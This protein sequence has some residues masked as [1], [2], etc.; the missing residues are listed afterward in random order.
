VAYRELIVAAWDRD[1]LL[2]KLVR[3][4]I[5]KNGSFAISA[6]YHPERMG[7]LMKLPIREGRGGLR[8][9]EPRDREV[10]YRVSGAVKLIY[11]STGF[12]QFSQG[13]RQ[14]IRSGR[15]PGSEFLIPKGLGME[16]YP[17]TNPDTRGP[18]LHATF[19]GIEACEPVTQGGRTTIL[20][21]L[22]RPSGDLGQQWLP[23]DGVIIAFT[24]FSPSDHRDAYWNGHQ[25]ILDWQLWGEDARFVLLDLP[26]PLAFLGI[27]AR[28]SR[29]TPA[30]RTT[31]G[32]E[33]YLQGPPSLLEQYVLVAHYP[34]DERA[35]DLPT[36]DFPADTK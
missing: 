20:P 36:I 35:T 4:L 19:Y 30:G 27:G 5:L 18:T 24:I 31:D 8:I 10:E 28:G 1:N 9:I 16:A 11:H 33:Y 25:W 14:R 12:V 3:V 32:P 34:A 22:G 6:P 17:I 7:T 13:D 26:T 23:G 29:I 21:F 2:R 15:R